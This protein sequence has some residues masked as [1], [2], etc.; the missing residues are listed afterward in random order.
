MTEMRIELPRSPEAA[1]LARDA[2][3]RW[4]PTIVDATAAERVRLGA[5]EIVTNVVRH[6]GQDET[7]PVR[8]TALTTDVG[9]RVEVR[10]ETSAEAVRVIDPA[11]RSHTGGFGMRIIDEVAERWGTEP[12]PPGLVW[13]EVGAGPDS[14]HA[15]GRSTTDGTATAT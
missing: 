9:V 8:M 5:S 11:E 2:L 1:R 14:A 6:S 3:D 12:G 4:L 10:Q 15:S 13:F 7:E